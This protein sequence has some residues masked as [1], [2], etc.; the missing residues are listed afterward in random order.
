MLAPQLLCEA[1]QDPVIVVIEAAIGLDHPVDRALPLPPV[2]C[3]DTMLQPG[4]T[5]PDLV[6][7]VVACVVLHLSVSTIL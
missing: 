4:V 6:L 2:H 5:R 3:T 1:G 7:D